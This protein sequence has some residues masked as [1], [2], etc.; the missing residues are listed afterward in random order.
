MVYHLKLQFF[1]FEKIIVVSFF[2]L[3]F[4]FSTFS[5]FR[6]NFTFFIRL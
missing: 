1:L 4:N 3:Y 2:S 6:I 5:R